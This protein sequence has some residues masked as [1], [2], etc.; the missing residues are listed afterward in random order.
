[1]NYLISDKLAIY[2]RYSTGRKTPDLSFYFNVGILDQVANYDLEAEKITSA[3][4]G[5]KYRTKKTSLFVTPFYSTLSNIPTYL[6]FQDDT[7]IDLEFY[8]PELLFKAYNAYGVELE[9]NFMITDNFS[10]RGVVTLQDSNVPEYETW[11]EGEGPADDVK[12]TLERL[13]NPGIP[14]T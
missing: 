10:V 12:V 11:I 4:L 6:T 2:G 7:S 8:V 3:E 9:G 13:E 5:L 1:L 14:C